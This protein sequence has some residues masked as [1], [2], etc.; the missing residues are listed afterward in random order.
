MLSSIYQ[1]LHTPMHSQADTYTHIHTRKN[2]LKQFWAFLFH[3]FSLCLHVTYTHIN[4]IKLSFCFYQKVKFTHHWVT[5]FNF[6][7]WLSQT[8]W[9]HS[10]TEL[11]H[12]ISS[13]SEPP[14]PFL[15]H[16]NTHFQTH[17]PMPCLWEERLC[18]HWFKSRITMPW[19]GIWKNRKGSSQYPGIWTQAAVTCA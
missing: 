4:L 13:W 14:S 1:T 6:W 17:K 16:T 10:L 3:L 8:M 7:I 11:F 12:P 18:L 9:S 5:P 19:T 2:L 15:L